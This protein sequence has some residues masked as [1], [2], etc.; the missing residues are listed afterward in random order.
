MTLQAQAPSET[1]AT[2]EFRVYIDLGFIIPQACLLGGSQTDKPKP[3]LTWHALYPG[4]MHNSFASH[5]VY[6]IA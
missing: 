5:R 2:L 6:S 4:A 1:H 3:Y